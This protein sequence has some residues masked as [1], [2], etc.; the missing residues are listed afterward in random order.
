MIALPE[1]IFG[2]IIE[3]T[4][5][6]QMVED[7]Q[8]NQATLL[9]NWEMTHKIQQDAKGHWCRGRTLVVP[10]NKPLRRALVKL[11]HD[12]TTAGHLS[13]DKTYYAVLKQYWWPGC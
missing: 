13:I 6:D 9:Q 3:A 12:S 5:L 7:E 11:N 10:P 4:V 8:Q 1:S 2:Q